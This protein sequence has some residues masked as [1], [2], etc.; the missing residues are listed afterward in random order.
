MYKP[1]PKRK[2]WEQEKKKEGKVM[3]TKSKKCGFFTLH[4]VCSMLAG[5]LLALGVGTLIFTKRHAISMGAHKMAD[6]MDSE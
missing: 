5:A 1:P 3:F 6:A 2:Y 4:P